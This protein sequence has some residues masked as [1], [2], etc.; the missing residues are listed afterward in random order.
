MSS[1]IDNIDKKIL[2]RLQE[3]ARMAFRKIAEELDVSESTV[4]VRVKKLQERGIIRTFTVSLAPNLLGKGLT[5][6][7]LIKANPRHYVRVLDTLKKMSDV[8]AIYDIT[9]D[10]YAIVK[11][12]T[13]NREEL[14][15]ILDRIG[16]IE[17][18]TST[19]TAI[20]LRE[21]KEERN[22]LQ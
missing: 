8:Y 11:V 5:A 22:L 18:I 20:V 6:F 19:E 12:R 3:N 21:V 7:V 2:V 15:K 13:S 4:F 17:G 1:S 16:L 10:Y 14:A 9:G